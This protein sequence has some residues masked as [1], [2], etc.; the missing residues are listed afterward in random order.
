MTSE[1]RHTIYTRLITSKRYR[2]LRAKFIGLHPCCQRCQEQ[3]RTT[4]AEEVHH[5]R[6]VEGAADI[7]G[8]EE[9]LMDWHNLQALCHDCHRAI[10]DAVDTADTSRGKAASQARRNEGRAW[11]ERMYRP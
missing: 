6:R 8:M 4:L 7:H 10:H 1:Q 3:G 2:L 9:R 5:I 11:A